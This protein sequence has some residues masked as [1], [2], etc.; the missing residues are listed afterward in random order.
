MVKVGPPLSCRD[1]SF[2]C[3]PVTVVAPVNEPIVIKLLEDETGVFPAKSPPLVLLAMMVLER[4]FNVALLEMP[5]PLLLLAELPEI[6]AL[7]ILRLPE[8]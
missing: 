2:I 6:V 3:A 1:P 8:L 4:R 5:P 7:V